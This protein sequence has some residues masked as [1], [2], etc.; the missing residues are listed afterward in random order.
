MQYKNIVMAVLLSTS[1]ASAMLT[2][3]LAQAQIHSSVDIRIGTPPPQPRY[4]RMPPPR[5]GYVW[6]P[7]YW[8]WD[9]YRHVWVGGHWE[10]VRR[11]YRYAPPGWHQDPGGW[12]FDHGGWGR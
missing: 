3:P 1:A 9:G 2:A 10:R 5:H 11:G 7:G 12:R 8:A 4:E 6:A